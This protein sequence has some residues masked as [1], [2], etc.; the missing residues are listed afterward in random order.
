LLAFYLFF[1]G[2]SFARRHKIK[3]LERKQFEILWQKQDQTKLADKK[4]CIC[5]LVQSIRHKIKGNCQ[6]LNFICLDLLKL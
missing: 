6:S 4:S 2:D 5:G 1:E 3:S